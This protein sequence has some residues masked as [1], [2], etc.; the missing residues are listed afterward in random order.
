M[1]KLILLVAIAWL[2]WLIREELVQMGERQRNLKAMLERLTERVD[3]L[4]SATRQPDS[5]SDD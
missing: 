2:L 5:G 3:R 1:I 4:A